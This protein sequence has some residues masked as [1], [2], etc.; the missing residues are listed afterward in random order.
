MGCESDVAEVVGFGE[1]GTDAESNIDN[2]YAPGGVEKVEDES[3]DFGRS[4]AD[5]VGC[6]PVS[7]FFGGGVLVG[8]EKGRGGV[9]GLTEWKGR[10]E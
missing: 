4:L 1:G 2:V 6:I 3:A 8:T 9:G 7:D 10:R 5:Y